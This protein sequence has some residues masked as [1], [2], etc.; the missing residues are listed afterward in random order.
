VPLIAGKQVRAVVLPAGG[1]AR[2]GIHVFA[3]GLDS[4]SS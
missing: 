4:P 3:V 2:V 1:T